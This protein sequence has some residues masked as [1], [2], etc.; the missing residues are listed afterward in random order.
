MQGLNQ[1]TCLVHNTPCRVVGSETSGVPIMCSYDYNMNFKECESL[2]KD[3]NLSVPS[4]A[5]K[6][7]AGFQTPANRY[8]PDAPG[9][10]F[11]IKGNRHA[12]PYDGNLEKGNFLTPYSRLICRN[13]FLEQT[14][15][16][17]AVFDDYNTCDEASG[18]ITTCPG[19]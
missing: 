19:A 5:I 3:W 14:T 6:P 9:R 13:P 18:V 4:D 2:C 16:C 7:C 12:C 8:Y 10:C 17:Y 15:S 1:I 11:L